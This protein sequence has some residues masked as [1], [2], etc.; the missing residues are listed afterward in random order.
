MI[1]SVLF[2]IGAEAE[3]TVEHRAY[4]N[5]TETPGNTQISESKAYFGINY[6]LKR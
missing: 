6:I 4:D 3:E 5:T 2:D 1:G